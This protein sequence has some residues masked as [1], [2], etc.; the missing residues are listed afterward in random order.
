[1]RRAIE[2]GL[3]LTALMLAPTGPAIAAGSMAPLSTRF[4][5]AV[6]ERDG[7]A[8]GEMLSGAGST[9]INTRGGDREET[10]LHIVVRQRDVAWTRLVL[11]KGGKPDVVD[12]AGDTPLMIATMLGDVQ[13]VQLL[14]DRRAS[15][16]FTNSRGETALIRAVQYRNPA[17]V[18]LLVARGADPDRTDFVAGMSA[19]DYAARDTRTRGLA[20][21]LE[22]PAAAN[23]PSTPAPQAQG[24][25]IR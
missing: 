6:E 4:L 13:I 16:D 14:L 5:K 3:I 25:G 15:V 1:M 11:V 12:K 10:A 2:T 21:A 19:R 9:L 24:P 8:F 7:T 20:E 17:L 22:R 18:R 23:A